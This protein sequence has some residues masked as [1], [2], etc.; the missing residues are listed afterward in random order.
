M[1]ID[2]INLPLIRNPSGFPRHHISDVGHAYT[3]TLVG[4]FYY[5]GVE[6]QHL[7]DLTTVSELHVNTVTTRARMS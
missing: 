4:P 2:G 3:P 6:D 1:A 5:F 7:L